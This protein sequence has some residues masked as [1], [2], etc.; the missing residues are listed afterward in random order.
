MKKL[1]I[2]VLFC[3]GILCWGISATQA[4]A[5]VKPTLHITAPKSGELWTNSMFTILGT[6]S[7]SQ[8]V[9]NVLYSLNEGS[10]LPATPTNSWKKWSA[11]VTPLLPGTNVISAYAIS[12]NDIYSTTDVVKM[13]YTVPVLLTVETNGKA[14]IT[15]DYKT[16]L[17][18]NRNYKITATGHD[19]FTFLD[20]TGGTNSPFP[21]LTNKPTLTFTMVSNLVLKANLDDTEK[22]Y[23][24]I[25]NVVSG[26]A[27]TNV[28][29]TVMGRA[30]DNVAVASVN[31][32]INGSTFSNAVLTGSSWS[33]PV[34]L[35]LGSNIF[36]AYAV[37]SSENI[38]L[39]NKAIIL[40]QPAVTK[41]EIVSNFV[42]N[43]QAQLSFDGTNYLV[44]YQVYSSS[45]NDTAMGQFVS[46]SG[47]IIGVHLTLNPE[48]QN[49]PPY[50]DFDGSNYLVAWADY[51]SEASGISVRGTFVSPGG[52][53]VGP[54]TTLSQSTTVTN[55][56]SIV[57]GGGVYF[58]MWADNRITPN[59]IYGA[60]INP[61][62]GFNQSGD[63]LISTNGDEDPASGI[64]A[65]FD[66]TNFLAVWY[67]AT[68]KTSVMGRFINTAGV[69]LGAP[70]VIY[71]NSMPAGLTPIS[72]TFDGTKYLVLFNANIGTEAATGYHILGRFVTP[73]GTVLTNQIT[74]T[75]QSGPQ[76]GASA[77]FDGVNYLISWNQ[78]YNPFAVETSTTINGE[79][80]DSEGKPA[81]AEF[82]IFTTQPGAEIP[83]WAPV[84][85]DGSKF[86][87]AGGLGHLTSPSVFTN[88]VIDG[89]FVAP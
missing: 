1:F 42:S 19:G 27:L 8:G 26:K 86:V 74:L 73:E 47:N 31:F 25:T 24:K 58:I 30:T 83:L 68:G 87:L 55:F 35:S 7:D 17:D 12:S 15:P 46:P 59:S 77:D 5:P 14:I 57:Y 11:L 61:S 82:P 65:A 63:F 29:F 89:A 69:P 45:S 4:A 76:I 54:V 37:D 6:A 21:I 88:S 18:I 33:T 40:R 50:L 84:L 66:Q 3:V 23:L 51:S 20:W 28:F 10:Y 71:A 53:T 22:P 75:S 64:S 85:W 2:T 81:S 39:T 16:P 44:V 13:V 62:S 80:F 60:I 70:F 32:S 34:T 79:F 56:G 41:F 72:V 78:G 36:T 38:S 43:P 67:S 9:S 52:T 48:G 49:S